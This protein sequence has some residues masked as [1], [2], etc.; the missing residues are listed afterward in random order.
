MRRFFVPSEKIGLNQTRICGQDAHHIRQ[1]LRLDPGDDIIVFDG[2]GIERQARIFSFDENGVI[3]DLVDILVNYTES[4]LNLVLAQG[5][6]KE[7]KMDTLVRQL[8]EL[9]VRSWLPFMAERS[10]PSPDERRRKARHERWQKITQE[11]VKQCRRGKVMQV[12]SIMSFE[13]ALIQSEPFDVKVIFWE[14]ETQ[15]LS[16]LVK[17]SPSHSRVFAMIGPEGGFSEKE[18]RKAIERGFLCTG[19]GPRI[20][21]AETATLAACTLLQY[22]FGDLGGASDNEN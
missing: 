3:V 10:I 7:K 21:R 17:N 14:N 4:P 16:A 15:P 5:F 18:V 22:L 13:E 9:G 8:T 11:A 1:V 20:L 2:Q 6:L 19:L 12:T